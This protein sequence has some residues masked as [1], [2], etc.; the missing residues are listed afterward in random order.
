MMNKNNPGT[1]LYD[2]VVTG[3]GMLPNDSTIDDDSAGPPNIT[4]DRAQQ[5]QMVDGPEVLP[6]VD[7]KPPPGSIV[8]HADIGDESQHNLLSA[9][10][11]SMLGDD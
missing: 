8:T 9:K 3:T 7:L 6:A 1:P 5:D 11:Y 4:P 2:A 10:K